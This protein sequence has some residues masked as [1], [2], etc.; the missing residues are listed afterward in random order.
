MRVAMNR[1]ATAGTTLGL[2]GAALALG[3][4][5][6]H[7][8]AALWAGNVAE[9]QFAYWPF[10]GLGVCALLTGLA[11]VAL[12]L[13]L[14]PPRMRAVAASA[15]G[16]VGVVWWLYG[17]L[18]VPDLPVL[19]GISPPITDADV[20]G[21]WE[22]AVII[23]L[24][25]LLSAA[26]WRHA[27]TATRTLLFLNAALAVASAVAVLSAPPRTWGAGDVAQSSVFRFSADANV[28]VALLDGLQSNVAES[29]IRSD[30]AIAAALDGFALYRDTLGVAPTTFLSMPAI[31]SGMVYPGHGDPG[32]YFSGEIARHS[33]M[34]RFADA[35]YDATLVNAIAGVCP[36]RVHCTTATQLL[37]A[38]G[39]RLRNESLRLLDLSLFRIAPFHYK[40]AVYGDGRWV[41]RRALGFSDDAEQVLEGSRVF[42]RMAQGLDKSTMTLRRR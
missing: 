33:F 3:V 31:H 4:L 32:T 17:L 24:T 30:P 5:F 40:P 41:M 26:M 10:L 18:L 38:T 13:Y 42:D 34:T 22:L 23:A 25:G 35:G 15:A 7:V 12:L 27:V 29:E 11:L 9:H 16:A 8:P 37:G 14:M 39:V 2:T 1:R 28:L 19:D 6:L 36:D 21:I 20:P